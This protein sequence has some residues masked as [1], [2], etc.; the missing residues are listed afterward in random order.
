MSNLAVVKQPATQINDLHKEIRSA[1]QSMLVKAIKLG[2]LLLDEK[3]RVG[4]GH[5]LDWVKV[6]LIFSP[7]TAQR[8][9][10]CY[11]HREQLNT[12]S[13]SHLADAVKLL[14]KPRKVE[15]P[16][17]KPVSSPVEVM[18]EDRQDIEDVITM[19]SGLSPGKDKTYIGP[20][21]IVDVNPSEYRPV[22]E[23]ARWCSGHAS[24]KVRRRC[25]E[26]HSNFDSLRLQIIKF[27]RNN[28]LAR[29]EKLSRDDWGRLYEEVKNFALWLYSTAQGMGTAAGVIPM[30]KKEEGVP[31]PKE[32]VTLH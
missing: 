10:T 6:N 9:I 7:R 19:T 5:W 28:E 29:K 4:H 26:L 15:E 23:V 12:T 1:A 16:P 17:Q 2:G 8:Y 20:E 31:E 3:Q 21:D 32:N 27:C 25:D 22:K 13:V 11:E 30:I 24:N 14:A 18:P